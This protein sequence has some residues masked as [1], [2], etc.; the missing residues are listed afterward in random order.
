V[1]VFSPP[2][3]TPA[4]SDHSTFIGNGTGMSQSA[5]N[6]VKTFGDNNMSTRLPAVVRS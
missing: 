5:L 3:A 1:E 6:T 4:A 2:Q